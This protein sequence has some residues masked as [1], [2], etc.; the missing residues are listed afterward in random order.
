MKA[1]KSADDWYF[2]VTAAGVRQWTRGA[3]P[4]VIVWNDLTV[5]RNEIKAVQFTSG[6][7]R[8]TGVRDEGS[9]VLRVLQNTR[10]PDSVLPRELRTH[11]DRRLRRL[12]K[13]GVHAR[14]RPRIR[15]PR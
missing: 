8:P 7:T 3:A 14:E 2:I 10:P 15:G 5:K 12:S 1:P 13:C 11:G 4:P 6:F 9:E